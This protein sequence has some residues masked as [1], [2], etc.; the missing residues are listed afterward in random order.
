MAPTRPGRRRHSRRP[1]LVRPASA[2][3]SDLHVEQGNR[4]GG[5]TS[6]GLGCVARSL[7]DGA[8]RFV[9]TERL[10]KCGGGAQDDGGREEFGAIDMVRLPAHGDGGGGRL[11]AELTKRFQTI[12]FGH[13]QVAQDDVG[14][15]LAENG[16]PLR[17]VGGLQHFVTGRLQHDPADRADQPRVVEDQHLLNG[18]SNRHPPCHFARTRANTGALVIR[19]FPAK[20]TRDTPQ[21]EQP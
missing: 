15:S 16:E 1:R 20:M 2:S 19:T 14:A 5:R 12:L 3:R 17:A 18:D 21:G 8:E 9:P 6:T 4:G 13:Q 10:V 11:S 7:T